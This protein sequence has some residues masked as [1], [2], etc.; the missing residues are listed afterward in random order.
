MFPGGPPV[1]RQTAAAVALALVLL[2]AGCSG[3][4]GEDPDPP[5]A[6]EA[7]EGFSSVG[8]YN[9]TVT[10]ESTVN[11]RT[12]EARIER[13]VRP[14]TGERYV[15]TERNG[16]LT[17]TVSNGTTNWRYRPSAN[18][19]RRIPA[20]DQQISHFTD[21]LRELMNSLDSE[22]ESDPLVPLPPLF[23]PGSG[24]D[25][26][27]DN[28]TTLGPEP[29]E[30]AYQGIETISGR[31]A[32]VITMETTEA[33]DTEMQQTLYYDAE[34]FVLLQS[35]YNITVEGDRVTGQT[36]VQ[37][38]DFSPS[39][40]ES[41]FEFEPPENVTVLNTEVDRYDTYVGLS[42][43][44][45]S[46]VPD[47]DLPPEFEFD[48]GTVRGE[49]LT[50][51]YTSGVETVFVTRLTAA[52]DLP[53]EPETIDYRGRTYRYS[54]EFRGRLIRWECSDSAYTVSGDL[55][56]ETILDVGAS[57]ECPDPAG[58]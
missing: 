49:N 42:L 33:A 26:G 3:I 12:T 14:A 41:L 27:S 34:Y 1:R 4:A 35:E 53:G 21:Q 23:A 8:V 10:T 24:T 2:L 11:N 31:D 28:E 47:P 32:H 20:E 19:V 36:R 52:T 16:T 54:D 38:V 30:T 13:T 43:G 51:E 9:L 57:I 17:L 45:D 6:S 37:S 50:M 22:S 7:V 48:S 44:S 56:R 46:H 39:V 5:D 58:D 55:E 25:S 40:D 15:V 29:M 18:Q